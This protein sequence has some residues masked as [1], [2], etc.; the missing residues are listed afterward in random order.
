MKNIKI[1]ALILLVSAFSKSSL[2][3][4]QNQKPDDN[5]HIKITLTS[6]LDIKILEYRSNGNDIKVFE[7]KENRINILRSITQLSKD[8]IGKLKIMV[9]EAF[10]KLNSP[11]TTFINPT[12]LDGFKWEVELEKN[13]IKKHFQVINQYNEDLDKILLF[14]NNNLKK[15]NRVIFPISLFFKR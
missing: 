12:Y 7:K 4:G 8:S 14:L 10:E 15:K 5:C 11:D 2:I 13:S 9:S 3:I 6:Y 1:V